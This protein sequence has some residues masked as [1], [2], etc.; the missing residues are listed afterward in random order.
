MDYVERMV[1]HNLVK[2]WEAQLLDEQAVLEEAE[3]LWELNP[4]W[5]EYPRSDPR[6]INFEVLFQLKSLH[7]QLIT[8]DDIPAILKFL[9]TPA[10]FEAKAWQEWDT[11]WN[12]IDFEARLFNLAN[13]PYYAKS[14]VPPKTVDSSE[15]GD[16]QNS[17]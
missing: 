17:V 12:S 10:G 4:Q 9:D 3:R 1:L 2:Q 6:S 15:A 7:V 11:F 13:N 8:P 5:P 14:P 16:G